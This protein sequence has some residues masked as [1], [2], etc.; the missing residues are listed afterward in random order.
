M[1]RGSYSQ[2]RQYTEA[3]ESSKSA[4]AA[5]E[6]FMAE[7][8][9]ADAEY[10]R[11]LSEKERK[12]ASKHIVVHD[13]LHI[14]LQESLQTSLWLAIAKLFVTVSY[15][16]Y[17]QFTAASQTLRACLHTQMSRYSIS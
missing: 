16:L 2:E 14:M 17:D 7:A 13:T 9:K 11:A 1:Y 8:N 15:S 4:K 6:K 12:L 5:Y 10:Q 3:M